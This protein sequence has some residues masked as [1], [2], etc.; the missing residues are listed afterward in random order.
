[1]RAGCRFSFAAFMALNICSAVPPDAL[2]G[3]GRIHDEVARGDSQLLFHSLRHSLP[4]L[5]LNH[6]RICRNQGCGGSA[7]IDHD[8][9]GVDMVEDSFDV[10]RQLCRCDVDLS[11]PGLESGTGSLRMNTIRKQGDQNYN[12]TI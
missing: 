1:M 8:R 7:V 4:H 10:S 11:C 12:V 9:P 5:F 2:M 6:A 3:M